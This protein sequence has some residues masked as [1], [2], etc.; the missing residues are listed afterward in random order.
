MDMLFYASP[1]ISKGE[2]E[3]MADK[4]QAS[5]NVMPVPVAP[6]PP[7]RSPISIEVSAQEPE[8]DED[9]SWSRRSGC[10]SSLSCRALGGRCVKPLT[11]VF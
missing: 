5:M 6:P 3:D 10:F 1:L 2:Y 7:G 9:G 8:S 11:L 4:S